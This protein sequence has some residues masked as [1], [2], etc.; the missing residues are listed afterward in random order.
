MNAQCSESLRCALAES[1][2]AQLCLP[3]VLQHI[4]NGCRDIMT[5]EIVDTEILGMLSDR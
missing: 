3:R 1:N 2:V 5:R 4:V